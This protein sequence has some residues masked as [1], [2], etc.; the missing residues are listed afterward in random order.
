M[1]RRSNYKDMEKYRKTRNAQ[2]RRYYHKTAFSENSKKHYRADE[3]SMIL[4][5]KYTD[6]ELSI[7]LGRSVGSIQ[8]KRRRLK[9][10]LELQG[11]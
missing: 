3:L 9:R 6:S 2:K 8:T 1:L 4:E 10:E 7:L 5:H 11:T